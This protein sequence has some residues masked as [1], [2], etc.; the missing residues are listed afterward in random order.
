MVYLLIIKPIN[1]PLPVV[2]IT[3]G[4]YTTWHNSART[5][6]LVQKTVDSRSEFNTEEAYNTDV[7]EMQKDAD[8]I[9][10]HLIDDNMVVNK[11][12]EK[13]K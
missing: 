3:A 7:D 13:F 6:D 5:S 10:Q 4:T 1:L 8:I 2:N 11:S 9:K 12:T